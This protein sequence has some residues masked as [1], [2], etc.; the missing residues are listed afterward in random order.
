MVIVTT[1]F[2]FL[3]LLGIT[4]SISVKNSNSH[5]RRFFFQGIFNDS[6]GV[7]SEVSSRSFLLS[8][9]EKNNK[10]ITEISE[11]LMLYYFQGFLKLF[12]Q[13]FI[14][15]KKKNQKTSQNIK[16]NIYF[17]YSGVI[18]EKIPV[19]IFQINLLKFM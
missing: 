7:F 9:S 13:E 12:Q 4:R 14:C 1:F 17:G 10:I 2:C 3:F 18:L 11:F 15:L 16:T 6:I 8:S 19:E 5:S